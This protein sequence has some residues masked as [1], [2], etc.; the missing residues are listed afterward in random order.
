M[1][2][3]IYVP[4]SVSLKRL[5]LFYSSNLSTIFW[6]QTAVTI[7]ARWGMGAYRMCPDFDSVTRSVAGSS[8]SIVKRRGRKLTFEETNQRNEHLKTLIN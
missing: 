4:S 2:I 5:L 1:G 6:A 3:F 8:A 7:V